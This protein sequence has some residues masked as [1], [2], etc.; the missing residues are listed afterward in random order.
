MALR[1]AY[2]LRKALESIRRTPLLQLLAVSTIG[3]SLLVLGIVVTVVHQVDAFT[4]RWDAEGRLVAYLAEQASPAQADAAREAIAAWPEVTSVRLRTPEEALGALRGALGHGDELLQGIGPELLPPSVE[5]T[6]RGAA[7]VEAVGARLKALPGLGEVTSVETGADLIERMR[8]VRGLVRV[9]GLVIGTLVMLAVVFIVS[10]TIRLTL[11]ARRDEIEILQLVGATH[12]FIRAPYYIEGALQG[13]GG[14]LLAVG[15]LFGLHRLA[16]AEAGVLP[17]LAVG[18]DGLTLPPATVLA[19]LAL[20]AGVVG[21][22]SSHFA[23]G[24]FLRG[25]EPG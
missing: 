11:F 21:V 15:L 24:R 22:L 14:G 19:T 23:V 4:A 8:A 2:F 25:R 20:G 3:V 7:D 9:G 10:N 18:L 5:V 13:T 6:L 16:L 1:P 17:D 12:R